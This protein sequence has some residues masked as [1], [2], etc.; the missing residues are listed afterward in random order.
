MSALGR[1]RTWACPVY[2]QKRTYSEG[3]VPGFAEGDVEL[4]MSALHSFPSIA[5]KG[6]PIPR[7]LVQFMRNLLAKLHRE[8]GNASDRLPEDFN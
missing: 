8:I 1:K 6:L 3:A 2:P 7:S 4:S 5:P